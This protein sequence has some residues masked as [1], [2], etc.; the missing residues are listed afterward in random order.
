VARPKLTL[1]K[2][3]V[4]A[5]QS[6]TLSI[7]SLKRNPAQREIVAVVSTLG[8]HSYMWPLLVMSEESTVNG[9]A[10]PLSL[11]RGDDRPT[12]M[13]EVWSTGLQSAQ[14]KA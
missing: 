2:S 4:T 10:K 14:Q 8:V 13:N 7:R 12:L 1:D 9:N 11:Q 5:G 6:V 3:T